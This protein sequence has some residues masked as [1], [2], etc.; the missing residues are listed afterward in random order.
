MME[1]FRKQQGRSG[2]AN[3]TPTS[4]INPRRAQS[5]TIQKNFKGFGS[6]TENNSEIDSTSDKISI[7]SYKGKRAAHKTALKLNVKVMSS[8]D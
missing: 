6:R 4:K 5:F 7:G 8:P 2:T 1:N 3:A